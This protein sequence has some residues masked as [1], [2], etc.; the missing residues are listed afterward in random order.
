MGVTHYRDISLGNMVARFCL[1][2]QTQNM[3]L[4][5]LPGELTALPWEAKRQN[6]DSLVQVKLAEDAYPGAYSGGVTLRQSETTSSLR[7][8]NQTVTHED[9]AV[10][11]ST[12]MT[13]SHDCRVWH[14]LKWYEGEQTLRLWSEFENQG[15]EP[16][17]LEMLSS[18]SLGGLTP[19]TSGDAHGTLYVHRLRSVWSME[20]RLESHCL[21]DLQLEPSWSGHAVRCERFGQVGSMPV[22]RWFPW[23]LVEDKQHHVFWGAQIAHNASWQMELYRKDDALAISGGLADQE[24]GQWSKIV[25]P[26]ERF[27]TPEAIVTVCIADH[28]DEAAQ[29]LTS[30]QIRAIE[31]GPACEREL[32]VLFNEYCTTWG[33]PSQENIAA[34]LQAIRGR[35]LSYFVIDCG[36]FK[37]D[38]IPWDISMGDYLASPTLFPDGLDHTIEAIRQEGMVPGIWFEIDNVGSAA[39]AYQNTEHLLH[40]NGHVLTTS[41]R[42]FWNM[43][44]PWVQAYLQERVIGFLKE[45]RIGYVKMDY[46]DSIGTGCDGFESLGEGLRRNMEASFA[47]LEKMKAE[48]PGL[49]LENCSSGGHKLEPLLLGATAMS[50]FSDA[51]E[52]PEIPIIAANLHRCIQ[53]RQSQIWA[54]IRK[55]DSL[56]RILYSMAATMLGRMCLSGD[57]TEL[58]GEQW[59]VIEDGIVFYKQAAPVIRDGRTFWFGSVGKSYRHPTGWQGI[60]RR[61]EDAALCVFHRF[62]QAE[63]DAMTVPLDREYAVDT[64]YTVNG[65]V[66]LEDE[67]LR[68]NCPE[69]MCA[70]AVLLSKHKHPD[71]NY[72]EF[73]KAST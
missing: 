6:I 41:M 30:G 1:D 3:E 66:S 17:S 49:L 55:T 9:D 52:C 7:F 72:A 64:I 15:I 22:N 18:F 38:G 48:I 32:P 53:P 60:L 69:E 8:R 16:I 40:R 46:N 34:I 50:S 42:R 71:A 13:C 39:R 68:W 37:E 29:I 23:L 21:E 11:V 2:Q 14:F 51:H 61:T 36:W 45:H 24:F 31:K 12:E 62:T 67:E 35:G 63:G 65:T 57:V 73:S 33:C 4:Q 20:G 58:T 19:F 5:L 70:C 44:D 28:L 10:I 26:G 27:I 25:V 59:Q 56:Q 43:T 47:F 54:V